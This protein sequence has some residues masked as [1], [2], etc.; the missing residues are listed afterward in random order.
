MLYQFITKN[1]FYDFTNLAGEANWSVVV[2]VVL[3]TF[4]EER[5]N[6]RSSPVQLDATSIYGLTKN[7]CNRK[8]SITANSL[9]YMCGD[10][11]SS[12]AALSSFML[13]SLDWIAS[14]WC[15]GLCHFFIVSHLHPMKTEF[16]IL[17]VIL[18]ICPLC[19]FTLCDAQ[20]SSLAW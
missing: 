4:F 6:V 16:F 1:W 15:I 13:L 3:A 14:T 17:S 12:P 19:T 5:C 9:Q 7:P 11:L 18:Y 8:S 20:L 2:D 10:M